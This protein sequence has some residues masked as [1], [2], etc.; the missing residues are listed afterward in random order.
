MIEIGDKLARTLLPGFEIETD[1][2]AES[3]DGHKKQGSQITPSSDA[4][5]EANKL[6][7]PQSH[8]Q[9]SSNKTSERARV[10]NLDN[11]CGIFGVLRTDNIG[12]LF[13]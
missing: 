11:I 5:D 12:I 8:K 3:G 6:P 1:S 4:G 2:V 7:W 9:S 13:E 10:D